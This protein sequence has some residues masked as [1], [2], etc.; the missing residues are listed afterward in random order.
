[1]YLL[2]FFVLFDNSYLILR[3]LR[4]LLTNLSIPGFSKLAL[5]G[6]RERIECRKK[7]SPS[8]FLQGRQCQSSFGK[9]HWWPTH[10]YTVGEA[11]KGLSRSSSKLH[12]WQFVF[13]LKF[14]Q[15]HFYNEV[16]LFKDDKCVAL[17]ESPCTQ[18][19]SVVWEPLHMF[20]K[21]S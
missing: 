17:I 9:G 4:T 2:S 18:L 20:L 3:G 5:K 8:E 16:K 10:P 1:M 13:S 14:S 15:V 12:L 7:R 21:Q 19:P 6:W 11:Y